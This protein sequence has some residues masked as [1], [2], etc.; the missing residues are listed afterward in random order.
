MSAD[1]LL[2]VVF[3]NGYPDEGTSSYF[4]AFTLMAQTHLQPLQWGK[5]DSGI[6]AAIISAIIQ[7]LL[8]QQQ[9]L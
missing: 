8:G 4:D 1:C 2:D 5:R 9:L 6:I 7:A 3:N